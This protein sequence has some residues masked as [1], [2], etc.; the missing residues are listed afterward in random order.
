MTDPDTRAR[1]IEAKLTDDE[2]F[3]LL[4]SVMGANELL[5]VRDERIP[6]DVPM[7]AGYVP[8]IPR[9]GV[10][11]LLMTDASLGVTNP[12][13]RPGDTATALPAGLALAASFNPAL[14]RA[15]G[16]AVAREARSRGFNVLLAGGINLARDP[17][18]GRNFEYLSEDP[19]LSATIAAESINGIQQQG[20]ISTIKHYSLNCNETNRNWLDAVIDADAHRESDLLAFEIAIGRSQPGA[21]M[22][23][24][25]KVNGDY[26][27][28]NDLLLNDILKVAWGYQ[29]WVMSDW[30]ATPSWE[31][32]LKGLDQESGAQID[33]LLWG[34]EAFTDR[35]RAAYAEGKLPKQR[36]SDMA[37]R[38][39]RSIF[40]VGA[41]RWEATP[42]PDMAAHNAIALD[43]ARQGVV[44]LQNRGLLPIEPESAGRIAVIGGYAQIG[45]PTGCGSSAVVPPGGYAAVIPIGAPG[46]MGSVRNL[47]LLPSSPLTEL[48][49]M[50]PHN[51]IEFDPGI[52]P[53]EAALTARRADIAVVFAVRVEGEG[54]DNAD[55]A[56]PWGQDAVIEAVAEAQP[57]TVVVL[58]TGNPTAM[59]WREKVNAI[60]QAWYPGQAGGQAIAE[61]LVGAANPCGR[62]PLTFPLDLSQTPRPELPGLG[63]PWG[64][65]ITIHYSEGA[66]VGYRW[67]ATQGH[68]PMFAFGHGLSYTRFERRDL[69]VSGGDTVT[70]SFTVVNT[71]GRAGTDV[72][73][74]YMTAAPDGQR[75]RLL[76]F[77][78][79]ELA[80]GESRRVTIEADPRV[81][82][83]YDG[84]AGSW[85]IDEG[86]YTLAVGASAVEPELRATV[87]LPGRTFG[88]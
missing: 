80:P 18:N 40:A 2:R 45:V 5:P 58:E 16:A 59:P 78:R 32:A 76:G 87:G 65:P 11:P 23:A 33:R 57:N 81:L 67:Y 66:E 51:T 35:L 64:T 72:P 83:R 22:T 85:R 39:L 68:R 8:G 6:A 71:G 84:S 52:S 54:F 50:L 28:G 73:Q 30:G 1:E 60:L 9:L 26:A 10:P 41:D 49:K 82:A 47:Y 25:N 55:L 4:A 24:Y 29:G 46:L 38:I 43:I 36:L 20:V 62:L 44:L 12:G 7:S 31:F 56:L 19:F 14:A 48:R 21:V 69:T 75:L 42:P 13:Y 27:S 3:S 37:R 61:I 77:E 79:V 17:R 88:R 34:A 70:A 86:S 53:A 15:S 74:L 63:A